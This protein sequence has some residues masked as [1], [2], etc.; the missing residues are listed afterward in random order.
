MP[1]S[2]PPPFRVL[3]ESRYESNQAWDAD[4]RATRPIERTLCC[5]EILEPLAAANMC[6]MRVLNVL[7]CDLMFGEFG[8]G[9]L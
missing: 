9:G 8:E 7:G 4:Q 5:F 1:V 3:V 2:K 6:A